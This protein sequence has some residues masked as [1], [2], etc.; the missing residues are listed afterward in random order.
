VIVE[1]I[2]D[3]LKLV[4]KVRLELL[5]VGDDGYCFTLVFDGG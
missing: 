3:A 5:L 2:L 1:R 4:A